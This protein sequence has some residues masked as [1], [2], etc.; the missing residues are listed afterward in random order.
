[1]SKKMRWQERLALK[2]GKD[3]NRVCGNGYTP[4]QNAVAKKD[5]RRI[6]SVLNSGADI[7]FL[8]SKGPNS[9]PMAIAIRYAAIGPARVLLNRGAKPDGH[10]GR[11]T[12]LSYAVKERNELLVRELIKHKVDINSRDLWS[13]NTALFHVNNHD[14]RLLQTLI[15]NKIDINAVNSDGKTALYAAVELGHWQKATSL[16]RAGADPNITPAG[17]DPIIL[18]L[19]NTNIDEKD[20]RWALMQLLVQK[21]ANANLVNK[22]GQSLFHMALSYHD[23]P[24]AEMFLRRSSNLFDTDDKGDTPL[25]TAIRW[26]SEDCVRVTLDIY[27]EVPHERNNKGECVMKAL[28]NTNAFR[29]AHHDGIYQMIHDIAEK[30]G[31]I[32]MRDDNGLPLLYYAVQEGNQKFIT[33][34]L[35]HGADPNISLN[36]NDSLLKMAIRQKNLDTIDMLLDF[37]ADPTNK[38]LRGWTILD[39]LARNGDR[40]SPIV[41][42][43]IAGGG[44]YHKQLPAQPHHPPLPSNDDRPDVDRRPTT[45]PE[46]LDQPPPRLRIK[47]GQQ[48]KDPKQNV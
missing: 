13:D 10:I 46:P 8:G 15:E 32:D 29:Y 23:I 39:E 7:E 42:R 40:E 16:L 21:G 31:D 14:A 12:F 41:Q 43:L 17:K 18:N 33:F 48:K 27:D 25:H 11:D 35:E 47:Q 36:D 9:R 5:V 34:L 3:P 24:T 37:G 38:S 2:L 1:M 30:G 44:A 28:T 6:S 19:M 20:P 22:R 45:P 4:L 26:A